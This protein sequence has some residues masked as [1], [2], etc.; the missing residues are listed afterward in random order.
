MNKVFVISVVIIFVLLTTYLLR[1]NKKKLSS[2]TQMT[3]LFRSNRV[4]AVSSDPNIYYPLF[5]KSIG[6]NQPVYT[7]TSDLYYDPINNI[8][9]VNKIADSTGST[10]GINQVLTSTSTGIRWV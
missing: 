10:G 1:K 8:L 7:D 4:G 3:S 2:N 5:S 6:P 9:K